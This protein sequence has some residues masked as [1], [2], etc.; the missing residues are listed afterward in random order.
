LANKFELD[1]D[2]TGP[3]GELIARLQVQLDALKQWARVVEMRQNQLQQG[4]LTMVGNFEA[5]AAIL[6]N[7]QEV[8]EQAITEGRDAFMQKV[9]E[10]QE[11]QMAAAQKKP[12]L[13]TPNKIVPVD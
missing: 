4:I 10:L 1:F 6:V 12:E 7:K 11:E 9:R 5:L 3:N 2:K 13:W 8:T